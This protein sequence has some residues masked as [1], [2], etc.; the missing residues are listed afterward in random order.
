MWG[1]FLLGYKTR[2][3]MNFVINLTVNS[4]N[5]AGIFEQSVGAMNREGTG[6]VVVPARQFVKPGGI[7][8]CKSILGLL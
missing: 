7:G 4:N 8:S 3:P 2:K 6:L 1:I 5:P